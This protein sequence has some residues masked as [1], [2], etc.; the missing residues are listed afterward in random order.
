M[1]DNTQNLETTSIFPFI[2]VK[3]FVKRFK[4]FQQHTTGRNSESG[5]SVPLKHAGSLS[6]KESFS[7]Q[8]T[9]KGRWLGM[10]VSWKLLL[11]KYY[12]PELAVSQCKAMRLLGPLSFPF[13]A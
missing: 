9:F 8:R 5:L 12:N 13:L 4:I 2:D 11:E 1:E 6:F 10:E 7:W 3:P